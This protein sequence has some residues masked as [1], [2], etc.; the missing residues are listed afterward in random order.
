[1]GPLVIN[2]Q[3]T[4]QVAPDPSPNPGGG[5]T[6]LAHRIVPPLPGL[7]E[8][9]GGEGLNGYTCNSVKGDVGV[10]PMTPLSLIPPGT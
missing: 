5:E 9:A 3:I 1:M 2:L 4:V 8:G 7:G 6:T 10:S